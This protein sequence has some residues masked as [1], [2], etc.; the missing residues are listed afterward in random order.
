MSTDVERMVEAL[1]VARDAVAGL[2]ESLR[3]EGFKIVLGK[4]LSTNVAKDEHVAEVRR[5]RTASSRAKPVGRKD[6]RASR[7]IS[8]L[9]LDVAALKSLKTY[10]ER[11]ELQGSEQI[12]FILANYA[13][14]H[15]T[16]EFVTAADIEYLYRQLVSQRVKASAVNDLADWTRALNWLAAPS[17]RKE[18]L[19]KYQ[20]G[21]VVSNSGLLRFHE[22]EEQALHRSTRDL[23]A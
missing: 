21:H 10:C 5:T 17:R 18:W 9:Q 16:L 14:E 11:F 23:K 15:T 3:A 12:A 4:L 1:H 20:D 6:S 2:D 7:P 8:S 19:A 13:R 22:L